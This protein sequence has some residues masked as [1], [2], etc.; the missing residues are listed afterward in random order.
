LAARAYAISH[1][2]QETEKE[3]E[4]MAS[5]LQKV[6]SVL[7]FNSPDLRNFVILGMASFFFPEIIKKDFFRVFFCEFGAFFLRP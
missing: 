1:D 5:F 6:G 7:W 2:A 3:L 4:A